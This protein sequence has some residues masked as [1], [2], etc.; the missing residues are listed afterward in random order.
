MGDKETPARGPV[1]RMGDPWDEERMMLSLQRIIQEMTVHPIRRV[2]VTPLPKSSYNNAQVWANFLIELLI[3]SGVPTGWF[4]AMVGA[5][6]STQDLTL[7]WTNPP[8]HT[9]HQYMDAGFLKFLNSLA[10]AAVQDGRLPIADVS[11]E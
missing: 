4:G 9:I 10:I 6:W 3:A 11:W 5:Q 1:G 7:M 2:D 8:G